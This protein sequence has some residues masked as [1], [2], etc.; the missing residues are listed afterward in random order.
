MKA[1]MI[2]YIFL[3]LALPG[4]AQSPLTDPLIPSGETIRYRVAA[5]K[6]IDYYSDKT[7]IISENDLKFYRIITTSPKK[8]TEIRVLKATMEALYFA[9]EIEAQGHSISEERQ[10]TL[11][12]GRSSDEIRLVDF[13]ALVFALRGYPFEKPTTLKI[14]I[15]GE[16]DE[17]DKQDESF[18]MSIKYVKKEDI[19]IDKK[20]YNCHRLELVVNLSGPMALFGGLVPKTYLWYN[21]EAP[22]YLVKYQGSGGQGGSGTRVVTIEDYRVK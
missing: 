3:L 6:Q 11:K 17:G 1:T 13:S 2:L 10:V 9:N 19:T 8:S 22:H 14:K 20:K 15:F 5:E 16:E 7:E 18:S 21:S 12:P 4:F